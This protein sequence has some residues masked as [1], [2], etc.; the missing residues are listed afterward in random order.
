MIGRILGNR[1]EILEKIGAGEWLR[2]T[3]QSVIS[4]TE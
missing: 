2:F 3:K 1:Y 4:L